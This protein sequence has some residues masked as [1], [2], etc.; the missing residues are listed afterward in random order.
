MVTLISFYTFLYITTLIVIFLYL[1]CFQVP[2]NT[3]FLS[4][5]EFF[6]SIN[7]YTKRGFLLKLLILQLSGLPPFCFFFVKVGLLTEVSYTSN[8]F[9][10]TLIF[11]NFF[12][13]TL[14]YLKIFNI[15]NYQLSNATLR[16][17]A[18]SS[19]SKD[20][21]NMFFYRMLNFSY[22]VYTFLL[23]NILSALF[24]MDYF[25]IITVFQ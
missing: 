13:S 1:Y 10:L 19:M 17:L 5:S 16:L 7:N 20:T 11:L 6:S 24:F 12:L 9:V 14:F 2:T 25:S 4:N 15:T 8:L 3:F 18:V 21:T 23:F 22:V